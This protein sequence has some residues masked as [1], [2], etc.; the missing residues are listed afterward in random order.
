M[1]PIH[2]KVVS[3]VLLSQI[4]GEIKILLMKRVKGDFWCH[5]AGKI[6]ENETATEAICREIYEETQIEAKNLFSA[7]YLEQFY[8]P[9]LNII[10]IIPAFVLFCMPNQE[11]LLNHEHTEYKW[12]GLSEAQALATFSNQRNL[13]NFVWESFVVQ[14]PEKIIGN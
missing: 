6:E 10:E 14:Q 12:C 7:D 8:E 5:V 11:V 2:S 9:K 3:C 4:E 13:Y 1:I